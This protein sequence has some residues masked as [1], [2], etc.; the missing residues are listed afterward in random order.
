MMHTMNDECRERFKRIEDDMRDTLIAKTEFRLIKTVTVAT[1]AT[2]LTLLVGAW[3]A[4][5][6]LKAEIA[7][8]KGS[9]RG[10]STA[11]K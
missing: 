4:F 5:S 3:S 11:S 7:M 2:M 1:A 10:V 6:D 8:L 9:L